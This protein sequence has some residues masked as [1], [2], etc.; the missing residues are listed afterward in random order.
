MGGR[1]QERDAEPTKTHSFTWH[2]F[3][4][5][6]YCLLLWCQTIPSLFSR[7]DRKLEQGS[8]LSLQGVCPKWCFLRKWDPQSWWPRHSFEHPSCPCWWNLAVNAAVPLSPVLFLAQEG[9]R[10]LWPG[11]STAV[12]QSKIRCDPSEASKTL[13]ATAGSLRSIQPTWDRTKRWRGNET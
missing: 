10:W 5:T 6:L 7:A 2:Y 4:Y 3:C 12:I 11:Q 13:R 1:Q 9:G 8:T